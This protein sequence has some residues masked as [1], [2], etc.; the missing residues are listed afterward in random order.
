MDFELAKAM[1][2][3]YVTVTTTEFKIL[4]DHLEERE[5][6]QDSLTFHRM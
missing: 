1:N 5:L 2:F 4:S 6:E 3:M